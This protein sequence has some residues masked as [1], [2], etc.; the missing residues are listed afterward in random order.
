MKDNFL[1]TIVEYNGDLLVIKVDTSNEGW[2]SFIDTWDHNWQ[3]Y[4]NGEKRKL[5]KLFGAYKT[6]K[7]N[8][9]ISTIKFI[10]KPFNFNLTSP[11][12]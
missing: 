8:P 7:I 5:M 2:V 3:V 12:N 4:V 11:S 1:F 10:Y 6:I 9:G